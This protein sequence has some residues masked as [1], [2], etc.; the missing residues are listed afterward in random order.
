MR[1]VSPEGYDAVLPITARDVPRAVLLRESLER[2][3]SG[4]RTCWVV[5]PARELGAAATLAGGRFELLAEEELL[6]D[7]PFWRRVAR[8]RWEGWFV[9]QL[10]K[11]AIAQRLATPFYLTL[12]ADVLAMRPVPVEALVRDGRGVVQVARDDIHS[13]WYEWAERVLG[14]RRSGWRHG[15]TPAVLAVEGVRALADWVEERYQQEWRAA[16]MARLPW[17]EY[18]LYHTFLETTGRFDDL[19]VRVERDVLYGASVWDAEA[20]AGWDPAREFG[21]SES[22]LFAVVQSIAQIPVEQVRAR[23]E[24]A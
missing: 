7:P 21:S 2:Y 17:T 3:A 1:P 19:H 16:L 4:M 8:R 13:D 5:A 23:L 9:Q 14:M 10:L 11:L 22:P 18:A 24:R 12:D 20:F 6:P 15:V